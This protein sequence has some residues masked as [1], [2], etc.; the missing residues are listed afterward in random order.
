[1][2]S[3]FDFLKTQFPQLFTHATHTESLGI[4]APRASC[5]YARFTLE[6]AV[7]WLYDNDAYLQPPYDN[8]L[9]ALIHE[10]TFKDNLKPGLFPKVRAI[11]KVGNLAAHS[12]SQI[13]S[14]DSLRIVEDLFH[15]LYWLCRYYSPNGKNLPVITFNREYIPNG[16]RSLADEASAG[17]HRHPETQ[18][19][20]SREQ[21]AELEAKLSQADEMKQIAE[22]R[23]Q[24]QTETQLKALK[25]EI[26]ALKQQNEAVADTHDYNEAETRYYLI[27]V[28]LKEA[29]WSLDHEDSREYKVEG[30][31][32]NRGFGKVDYVLW[33]DD[34]KP[35]GLIEAKRTS[36]SPTKGKQQ[37][38]LYADCLEQKFGQRP[39][40]FYSNGYNHWIWDDVSAT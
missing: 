23:Q 34:G 2:A 28:L 39:V 19:D 36:N 1:M 17:S 3:N 25:Q 5:F 7:L 26:A 33:G 35:L 8:N 38:K 21:L 16:A 12:S 27:D 11:H 30:M 29:G 10:Q 15:F 24:Q 4:A 9:G 13:T 32:N 18:K 37:A 20:M 31:P 22:K 14:R 40:I 6:Q